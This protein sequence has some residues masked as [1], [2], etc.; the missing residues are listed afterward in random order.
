MLGETE[1]SL[2]ILPRA[3]PEDLLP[4]WERFA[5]PLLAT[6]GRGG[7]RLPERGSLLDVH[8]AE[9]SA[10]RRRGDELEV[11]LWNPSKSTVKPRVAGRDLELGPAEI[12]S[13]RF[14]NDPVDL[15]GSDG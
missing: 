2:G 8:G 14:D 1:L 3:R 13:V 9:L 5:L 15:G 4:A 7:N 11:R 10:I 12:R 6:P